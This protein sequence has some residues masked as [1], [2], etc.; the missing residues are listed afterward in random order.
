MAR[1]LD[2]ATAP[3]RTQNAANYGRLLLAQLALDAGQPSAAREWMARVKPD[4]WYDYRPGH[5][6]EAQT[7]EIEGGILLAEG[8]Q[9]EARSLLLKARALY[10]ASY[11][12]GHW[13]LQRID[14]LLAGES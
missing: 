14:R 4:R 13:R 8:R 11:L 6:R 2:Q 1:R 3:G 9:A 5:P 12:P 7:A 10:A